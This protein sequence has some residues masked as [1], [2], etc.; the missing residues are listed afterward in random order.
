M[1]API[2]LDVVVD[3]VC[4]WCWVGKRQ[5]DRAIAQ[6]PDQPFEIGYR[7]FELNPD[8]PQE[9]VD[10]KAYMKAKFGDRAGSGAIYEALLK[11]GQESGI[12][13][14]F[15][16]I[17]VMPNSRASHRLIRWA[18]S[19]GCQGAVV[20]KL[21][22]RYFLRGENIGDPLVLIDVASE[23]GMDAVLVGELL[24]NDSDVDLI[25]EEEAIAHRLGI[26]GVPFVIVNQ[27]FA[28][29]GAQD[30]AQYVKVFDK[31]AAG[32]LPAQ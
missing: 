31:I 27:Q 25:V 21:F 19:A 6:R 22:E 3:T 14:D 15:D 11:A 18:G 2:R 20:E 9:G 16:R 12:A 30:A 17:P 23:A 7:P 1:A 8:M 32:D 26:T 4:P 24:M 13:F 29:M 28:V 10:R 5:L